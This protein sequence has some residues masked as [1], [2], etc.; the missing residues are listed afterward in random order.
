MRRQW[1]PWFYALKFHML[2]PPRYNRQ[3]RW[4]SRIRVEARRG[5]LSCRN[6][7]PHRWLAAMFVKLTIQWDIWSTKLELFNAYDPAQ[8]F[9]SKVSYGAIVRAGWSLWECDRSNEYFLSAQERK[10]MF[11]EW[12]RSSES[13]KDGIYARWYKVMPLVMK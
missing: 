13:R 10:W 1:E 5:S 8:S 12:A 4:Q 7:P 9:R 6:Y 11:Y 2:L 3:A